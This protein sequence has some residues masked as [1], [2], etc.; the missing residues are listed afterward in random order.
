MQ[1]GTARSQLWIRFTKVQNQAQCTTHL[2]SQA[3]ISLTQPAQQ[4]SGK[5]G[6][7]DTVRAGF[8]LLDLLNCDFTGRGLGKAAKSR[9]SA[10]SPPTQGV[11]DL[12]VR[13]NVQGQLLPQGGGGLHCVGCM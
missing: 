11:L 4:G 2:M 5:H 3:Y 9:G 10:G 1:H 13:L 8:T 6:R 7:Q 12:L